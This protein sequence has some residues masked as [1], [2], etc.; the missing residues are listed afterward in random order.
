MY[1]SASISCPVPCRRLRRARSG[2]RRS[3][4]IRRCACGRSS[5]SRPAVTP[6]RPPRRVRSPATS[7]AP[8]TPAAAAR[9]RPPS[10]AR[11][12]HHWAGH[13]H[14]APRRPGRDGAGGG[15]R[16]RGAGGRGRARKSSAGS[17]SGR[18]A[19][20]C[21]SATRA[22]RRLG[23]PAVPPSR[24]HSPATERPGAPRCCVRPP[25]R[26]RSTVRPSS[27]PQFAPSIAWWCSRRSTRWRL[28]APHV[29]PPDLLV[30]G[31]RRHRGA[32]RTCA[33]ARTSLAASGRFPATSAR[34]RDR[35][36]TATR[37]RGACTPPRRSGPGRGSCRRLRRG[38]ASRTRS[39]GARRDH[40][41]RG[42]CDRHSARPA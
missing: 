40:L 18:E 24:P 38:P 2:T 32:R 39:R 7:R 15:A 28:T 29:V 35:P 8:G 21:R 12:Y 22:L 16:R 27:N 3:T 31:V 17:S 26:R 33:R 6:G 14:R 11:R 20:H 9:R 10:A 13:A 41:P 30:D 23:D 19:P 42:G 4:R 34:G 5:S 36:R 1:D 37:H 25:T